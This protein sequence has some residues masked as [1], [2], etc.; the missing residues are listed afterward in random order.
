MASPR[1]EGYKLR[2]IRIAYIGWTE[3]GEVSG[4]TLALQRHLFEDGEF[5]VLVATDKP[6]RGVG[7][8]EA[9]LQLKRPAWYQRLCRTRLRRWLA[10]WEMV[11]EPHLFARQIRTAVQAFRPEVIV[12]IPD[13]TLS[14]SAYLLAKR[15]GIPLVNNF[16]DW[17]PRG[18]LSR[19]ET[20]WLPA[21]AILERRFRKVAR[22]S[23]V[24]FCTSEGFRQFLGPHPDAPVL[25]PCPAPRPAERPVFERSRR[26][27]LQVVYGGT[28]TGR[29]G[30][31]LLAL[32]RACADVP[33]IALRF[34]GPKPDWR[35]DDVH[36]AKESG[37]Y[38]G[39]LTPAAFRREL[40][41]G[42][43]FIT[44]MSGARELRTMMRTSFTTKFLE[45]CQF[46]RPVIVWGPEYCQ[47]VRVAQETGAGLA[48]TSENPAEVLAALDRLRDE[49]VY[50]TYADNAWWAATT[51]FDPESIHEV[52]R[53]GVQRAA[54]GAG[55]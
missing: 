8:A 29:Y 51:F 6:F 11:V 20:P 42:D 28:L 12:T 14:W 1:W 26:D 53:R 54:V 5:E 30:E 44:A 31:M 7:N 32:A 43:V 23:K 40:V 3:P 45:Y 48:V 22:R 38:G 46:A 49:S 39:R 24:A 25:Y 52:F 4:A 35:H 34:F 27:V 18:Q 47:P 17:W 16:Q 36:W 9:W 41:A 2:M 21:R 13:N 33:W 50:Q 55:T 15:L 37:I 10:H 19:P